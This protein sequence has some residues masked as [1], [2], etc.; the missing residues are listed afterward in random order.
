MKTKS[1]LWRASI[2]MALIAASSPSQ[3]AVLDPE[4]FKPLVEQFNADDN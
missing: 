3:A 1:T 2:A 4:S